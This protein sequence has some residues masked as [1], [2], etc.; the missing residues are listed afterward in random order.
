MKIEGKKVID[1]DRLVGVFEAQEGEIQ[2]YTGGIGQ[3]K[4]Y[5]ATRRAIRDL[6]RGKV[7]W[8]NWHMILDDFNGD[9][10]RDFGRAIINLL[11][12]RKTF[13]NIDIKKNWHYFDMEEQNTWVIG[14]RYYDNLIDFVSTLTDCTVYLDEGQDIFDSYEGTNMS[15]KKRK[16]ITRTR[17][18]NKTLVVISQR[19]QAIAVTARANVNTFYKHIRSRFSLFGTP[20]F[21]LYATEEIDAQNMPIFDLENDKP[22][23][24]YFASKKIFNAYNSKYLRKGLP[25]SQ[26]VFFEAYDFSF[27]QRILHFLSFFHLLSTPFAHMG[28]RRSRSKNKQSLGVKEETATIKTDV[29]EDIRLPVRSDSILRQVKIDKDLSAQHAISADRSLGLF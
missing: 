10:R 3:G 14:E 20:R 21:K 12:F 9:Q 1:I 5:G 28:K 23:E 16:S 27:F 8:T 22:I 26:Q 18:L 4:T 29:R 15:K 7:V 19:P 2:S 6:Q 11:L 25:I 24:T 13:Y 17:H